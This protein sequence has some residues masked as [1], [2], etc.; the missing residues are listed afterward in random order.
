[1]RRRTQPLDFAPKKRPAQQRSQATYDAL[2]DACTGLLP[3]LGFAGTTTNHIAQRAGVSVASLYE[4]FPGKDAI[5]AKVAERLVQRVIAR[6]GEGLPRVLAAPADDS[7]RLWID[8]IY[9]TVAREKELVAVFQRE[10]PY[11]NQLEPVQAIGDRLLEF[12]QGLRTRVGNFVRS[13]LSDAHLHLLINL[14][15][16]TILQCVLDP[17]SDISRRALLEEL[18]LR[19]EEWIRP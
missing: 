12:S 6:L 4:Y 15:S 13:D 8:L 2:V 9:R 16:S 10:V 3:E 17:P 14:V 5:V 7:V 19:V 18:T 1:M 11:T